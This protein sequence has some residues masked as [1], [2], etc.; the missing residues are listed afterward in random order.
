MR[1]DNAVPSVEPIAVV[2]MAGRFPEA[3]G[4]GPLW[5]NL[6]ERR[7][8]IREFKPDE[9]L[10][11]GVG[12]DVL[13]DPGYMPVGTEVAGIDRFDADFFGISAAEARLIDP[14][15]RVFL[16]CAYAAVDDAALGAMSRVGVFASS[17]WSTYLMAVVASGIDYPGRVPPKWA[18]VANDKDFLSTRVSYR[19]N[20]TGP[21]ITVQS[22]CSSSL[23]AVH[24]A[25]QSLRAGECDAALAGGVSITV[26]QPSGYF[27]AEDAT[28]S[29]DGRCRPFDADASGIVM[30][31]GSAVVVLKRLS[32]ALADRDHVYAVIRGTG[33]GNDGSA[34]VGYLAPSVVGIRNSIGQALATSGIEPAQIGY[35]E[36]HG[37]GTW[38]G[39]C[40]EMRALADAYGAASRPATDCLIGSVK[41]NI[42]NLAMAAGVTALVKTALILERQTVPPQ[43]G[44]TEPHP[45]LRLP[46]T[47]FTVPTTV[48]R[49]RLDAAAITATG[50]GGTNVHCVL[51]RP[52][53]ATRPAP[54]PGEYVVGI[55]APDESGLHRVA[56]ALRSH[57]G[58]AAET[59]LDDVAYTLATGRRRQRHRHAFA[60][61]DL[62]QLRGALDRYLAGET[63]ADRSAVAEWSGPTAPDPA[64]LGRF[65]HARHIPLPTYP[66]QPQRHWLEP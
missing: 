29:R 23:V 62:D 37:T 32:D 28:F 54:P 65:D 24:L 18:M 14:Q 10:R 6:L 11:A 52:P 64:R 20:L 2:G 7:V 22:A 36:M 61:G 3:A 47:P 58:D 31:N 26:P 4:V 45:E 49:R 51:E 21:S 57:L 34:K 59:R 50:G 35:V 30:G 19:L 41:A 56:A 53:A 44:F 63:D 17:L 66:F 60:V 46:D 8:A 27:P 1:P 15:Q 9:L 55:S 13:A 42:G 16:E 39:D 40:I 48:T 38:M 43:A 25:C 12:A 33:V 5:R